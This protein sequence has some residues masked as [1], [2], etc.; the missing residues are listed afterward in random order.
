[1]KNG[2]IKKYSSK[3][4]GIISC[5][6][7]VLIKGTLH[8]VGHSE[9]MVNLLYRRN[10]LLKDYQNFI[11]P[12]RNKL[13]KHTEELAKRCSI[14]IE[15]IRKINAVRKEDLVQRHIAKQNLG[16][17][18][19]GLVCILSAM[20]RCKSYRYH[21]DKTTGRST[22]KMTNGKC[23]HYYFYFIDEALGLCHLRVPTWCPFRLQFYFNG[24]NWL[25]RSLDKAQIPYELIDN[26]IVNIGTTNDTEDTLKILYA[27]VQQISDSFDIQALQQKLDSYA[28]QFCPVAKQLCHIG[29]HWSIMQA[30]YATD[31]IFKD[32]KTVGQIYNSLLNTLIQTVQPVDIA[33]FLGR[34]ALKNGQLHGKNNLEI[35]TSCK[36]IAMTIDGKRHLMR[37][38]KHRMGSSSIKMYDKFSRV[39]RI[40]TTTNNPSEFRHY[41]SVEQRD[42]VKTNKLAPV[43]KYIYSLKPLVKIMFDCNKRYLDF[44][45]A[46]DQPTIGKKRLE[47]VTKTSKINNR[48]YKGFNFF[49]INDEKIFKAIV[50]GEF[51]I[52]GFRNQNLKD[53]INKN[54]AQTSRIIKRLRVKGIIRKVNK[55]YRYVVTKLGQHIIAT[56]LN[57]KELICTKQLEY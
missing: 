32:D 52:N 38:I 42:G 21:Y 31:I 54:T 6:D 41:R 40:E 14:E 2:F 10:V 20:E 43:R 50:K 36:S 57:F 17:D 9:A 55:S 34:K 29:Y 24:H 8:A 5:Y 45:A 4:Q 16:A 35:D 56:A 27:K 7:R 44:I 12:Y 25:A 39:L 13:H 1:M 19:T 18:Y 23:L 30:E 48:N 51:I 47:K 53:L 3:I 22:L 28:K 11:N 46:F 15:F 49:D 37:R 33:K 26:A